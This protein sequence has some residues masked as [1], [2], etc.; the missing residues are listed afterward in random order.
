M[1]IS[2]NNYQQCLHV[3]EILYKKLCYSRGGLQA[4]HEVLAGDLAL[5]TPGLNGPGLS[6]LDDPREPRASPAAALH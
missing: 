6:H 2:L 5:V 3:K 1:C 4:A